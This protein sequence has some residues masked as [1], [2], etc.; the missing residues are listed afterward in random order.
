MSM[1]IKKSRLGKAR[2]LP[3]ERLRRRNRAK[4]ITIAVL[5]IVLIMIVAAVVYV[6]YSGL[7]PAEQAAIKPVDTESIA[8]K[9]KTHLTDPNA[10]V[11]IVQQ[12]FVGT[13]VPPANAFISIKTNTSAA[14]QI[15][16]TYHNNTK[17]NDTGLV[18]KIADDFGV[19]QW[20]WSV[21]AGIPVGK[22]P[23]EITCANQMQKSGYYRVFLEV[24]K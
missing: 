11:G 4:N 20:S 16:V 24:N 6:W 13:V 5:L 10:P 23:V 9:I 21:P 14:C 2:S 15:Q 8:P 18:P 22:Y 3:H 19:V 12:T 7:N 1:E 17:S